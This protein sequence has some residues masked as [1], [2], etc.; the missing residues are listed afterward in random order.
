MVPN[1]PSPDPRGERVREALEAL[2]AE[3]RDA[4]RLDPGL[5]HE[6]AGILDEMRAALVRSESRALEP[7]HEESL[8]ERL[9]D[10]VVR[11][12]TEHPVLGETI[13]RLTKAL[14]DLGI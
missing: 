12:E 10:A 4:D 14:A 9:R 5:R 13:Q 3:L 6:L 7:G 1:P 2:H 11:L 8:V